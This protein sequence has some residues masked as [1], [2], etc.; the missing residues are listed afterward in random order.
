MLTTD[1]F[2]FLP[3]YKLT[4]TLNMKYLP[5]FYYSTSLNYYKYHKFMTKYINTY[6]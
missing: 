1:D 5:Q 3:I 2:S 4:L 6:L